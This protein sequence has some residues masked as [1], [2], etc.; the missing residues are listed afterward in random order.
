MRFYKYFSVYIL[1]VC[2][3]FELFSAQLEKIQPE[4]VGIS[5]ERLKN[6]NLVFEDAIA[7][8][9]FPGAVIAIARNGKLVY[10]ESFGW[11]NYSKK[12]TYEKEHNI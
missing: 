6:I 2:L 7:N 1:L 5:S 10:F 11:Q 4:S 12:N 9:K 8:K 3:N